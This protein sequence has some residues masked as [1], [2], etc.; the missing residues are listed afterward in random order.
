M[1]Q[2]RDPSKLRSHRW[3]GPDD[4]RSFGHRSRLKA[5]GFDDIDY[6]DRPVVAIL[7]TWSE[8]NTCLSHFRNRGRGATGILQAGGISC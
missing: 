8:L 6:K 7:N 2:S 1:T 4:M 3:F 5:M